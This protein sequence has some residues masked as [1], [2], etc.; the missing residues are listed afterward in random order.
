MTSSG[1][2][3][4]IL[5]AALACFLDDGYEQTTVARITARSG[6]SNG[7]LFH[8]F[9][10]KEAIADAL[11][12]DA[13]VSFQDGLWT[14]VRSKPRSLRAAVRGTIAHLLG[15]V[16]QHADLARFVYQRG[17]LDWDTPAGAELTSLN[18]QLASAFREWMKPLADNGQ[19]RQTSMLMI[20]AI[21]TGPAHAVA[22]RWLAGGQLDMPLTGCTDE[23]TDAALAGL[24]GA[25]LPSRPVRTSAIREGK[26]LVEL[27][28]EDGRVI[29]RGQAT[30]QL[31]P[32]N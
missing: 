25:P 5:D 23:L 3:Q 4:R 11:Y 16:E 9:P 10:T 26:I 20:S 7:A 30:A 19:L 1:T 29:A 22:R 27:V 8:H 14:L 12:L 15:W 32:P 21:V 2:R 18:R 17:H 13:M 24:R 28:A 31:S 6:A